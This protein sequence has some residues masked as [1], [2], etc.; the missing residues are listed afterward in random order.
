MIRQSA[1]VLLLLMMLAGC[2]EKVGGKCNRDDVCANGLLC[3]NQACVDPRID[4][5]NCGGCFQVCGTQN[6]AAI[7]SSST[8]RLACTAGFADCNAVSGDGCEADLSSTTDHCGTCDK[9]CS[10]AN[11]GA[12]CRS[13]ACALSTCAAN[14]DDCDKRATNGCEADLRTNA[15]NCGACG[16]R[17]QLSNARSACMASACAV[18][19]CNAGFGNCDLMAANGCEAEFAKDALH[20]GNCAT[21][22]GQ[23][24]ECVEGMCVARDLIV[25]GGF[26]DLTI[27]TTSDAV[28]KFN[29]G[30]QMFT[31]LNP[32]G[33]GPGELA[34]MAYAWDSA[35]HRLLIFG[36]ADDTFIPSD[37]LWA[38]DFTTS[39]PAWVEVTTTGTGPAARQ[40]AAFAWDSVGRKLY[41]FGGGDQDNFEV[42]DDLFVF[43]AATNT[44]SS[45]S[46]TTVP[47]ARQLGSMVFE[48]ST[49]KLL[50][51]G[52][53]DDFFD[54]IEDMWVIEPGAATPNWQQLSGMVPSDYLGTTFFTGTTP[55]LSFGGGTSS[56]SPFSNAVRS[57]DST[58]GDVTVFSVTGTTPPA[59][60]FTRTASQGTNRYIYGG[61]KPSASGSN[62]RDMWK[63]DTVT[64]TWS[65]LRADSAV[66]GPAVSTGA[67][68]IAIE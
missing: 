63:F 42:F 11:A 27:G 1:Q 56:G 33:T 67:A 66:N 52:G 64:N 61:Q 14:F 22:C 28:W 47:P 45:L 21:A 17:C 23:G 55:L 15:D 41:I 25:F 65:Q 58:T 24:Q 50:L 7:C 40:G 46:S 48:Q 2:K 32:T 20:C 51:T 36:G 43:D 6:A 54:S 39:T 26:K 37:K 34:D 68:F 16:T 60:V 5:A 44:W 62:A 38:L 35:S 49:G 9:A 18:S 10:Y 12:V 8:C 13:S 59:R 31:Q 29:L 57:V 30:T 19:S 53:F 3:C 4:T